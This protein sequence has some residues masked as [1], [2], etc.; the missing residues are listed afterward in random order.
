[1]NEQGVVL[2]AVG[3]LLY[4]KLAINL[5]VSIKANCENIHITL[6]HNYPDLT[7]IDSRFLK[8]IDN[9][10][11]LEE[12]Y[13]THE[14]QYAIGKTKTLLDKLTP[15]QVSAYIDVDS[16]WMRNQQ[17]DKFFK[18]ATL[19][20][21]IISHGGEFNP[22]RGSDNHEHWVPFKTVKKLFQFQNQTVMGWTQSSVIAWSKNAAATQIFETA[23]Q[24]FEVLHKKN[25]GVGKWFNTVPDE[26]CFW[27]AHCILGY[28][29]TFN[30]APF[31]LFSW[32]LYKPDYNRF[33]KEKIVV[34]FPSAINFL[35]GYE[36]NFY[37]QLINYYYILK[38]LPPLHF[39]QDKRYALPFS[40]QRSLLVQ[41]RNRER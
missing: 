24:V 13:Y 19:H 18:E 34:T 25:I 17:C 1:M 39:W 31:V 5:A 9:Y 7:S 29:P 20:N 11:F 40:T 23:Y 36:V 16:L 14:G 10:V 15:Y 41:I 2:L 30:L 12:E 6:L 28:V 22:I 4:L 32:D 33:E 3:N 35:K 21:F 8:E 38:K 26:L 37:N 27:L